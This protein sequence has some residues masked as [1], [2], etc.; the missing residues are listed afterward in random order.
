MPIRV[1][2]P[3]LFASLAL[4]G[5]LMSST[6]PPF[7]SS[8]SA[9]DTGA[10]AE[11]SLEAEGQAY[12][13]EK[14]FPILEANCFKC[15]GGED[16]LKGGFRVTS[17]EGLLRGGEL[18]SG[19]NPDAPDESLLLEMVSYKD[20]EHQMPP[21]EKL[22]PE[23]LAVLTEWFSRGA[24]YDPAL[25]IAGDPA[26]HKRSHISDE[27][28][29]YWA[30]QTVNETPVPKAPD[31]TWARNPVDAFISAKL[32]D[33]GL[34]PSP[35]ATRQVLV[36]RAYYDLIGLPPTPE[37][38]AKFVNDPRPEE[39]AWCDLIEDL[40]ERPQYGEKW[41]RHWLDLVRYA[42]TNGFERDN[43]KPEIWR[44]RDYI[45]NAFNSDKPYDRFVIEQLAGDELD[46]PTFDSLV[47]TGFH[48]LMQWDDEPADRKQHVYDVLADNLQVTAETFLGSTLGCARCHDHKADP[49][50][51]ED[52][53][54]FMAFFHGV[55]HYQTEGTLIAWATEAEKQK[56]ETERKQKLADL[57]QQKDKLETEILSWLRNHDFLKEGETEVLTFVANALDANPTDWF[58]AT[59][60]PSP[61]WMSVGFVNKSWLK[62]EGG[63][64]KE[65]TP[66]A[67]VR[68]PWKTA[69]IWM[70]A[71]FGLMELPETLALELHHDEDVE[72]YL[73]GVEVYRATGFVTQYQTIDLGPEA[74]AALQTGKNILAIHCH[75][76]KGGQYVDAA[77]RTGRPEA[78]SIK[79]LIK[80]EGGP[81]LANRINKDFGREIL[82]D[83]S[84]LE[85]EIETLR[86][87][88]PGIQINGVTEAGQNPE[89]MFIHIR[90]SAHAEGDPV[91]PAFPAVLSGTE[92]SKPAVIPAAYQGKN[93]SGRRRILAEWIASPENPLTARVMMNRLWQ[94]H[95]GRGIVPSTSDFGKLGE[96]PT[97]P[98]LLNWLAAEFIRQ[99]WS[100]K[101][102]HRLLM[103]SA[104]YQMSS[105]P[106][107]D[108]LAVDPTNNLFWRY[109]MRRL[110]AEEIRDSMLAL[111]GDLNLRQGGEPV[112]PPL[113]A[114]VL[115]TASRPDQAWGHSS[116]EDAARRSI[117]V[118]VKRSMR[119]PFLADFDQADTD[120]PCAVRFATTV[121]T[122]SL[123]MLNSEFVNTQA[124]TFARRIQ[125]EADPTPEAQVRYA[126]TLTLNREPRAEEV[127]EC[128]SLVNRLESELGMKPEDA[129]ERLAL[130]TMNLNEFVY[131]D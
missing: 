108:A 43:P 95:F 23:H 117:Y 47:A 75:Q 50:T 61:D 21:K 115:Q 19:Y 77:L 15:H 96:A 1:S 37:E 6:A 45:I 28:R 59:E 52:Y 58:Y 111:S 113:P 49:F 31:A 120:V 9:A 63:F 112:F 86:H 17:R 72:V 65:G 13:K 110:T 38:V 94:H 57:N 20:D 93:T 34:S 84:Q 51:Q 106:R 118:H 101:E 46:Q 91:A 126:L 81:R 41:A 22:A 71:Q 89:P 90:G 67:R 123:C 3:P 124:A 56:F 125:A 55:T 100:I 104:T 105:A 62:A 54:S 24:P 8:A 103:T 33:S 83:Y 99:G 16:K 44:Y 10:D 80:R 114:E 29:K 87:Q 66:G 102:M 116:P 68:T 11:V 30:Y 70:R 18:G 88:R 97:H 39:E 53:Y 76:T 85:T 79:A 131:L 128:V 36:R 12:Y 7:L 32:A 122:Q 5:W 107:Q 73:N 14:V 42:E 92:H 40:L 127:A 48:R 119:V 74:L 82:R 2:I 98:E 27:D 25:E 35:R 69:D 109:S 129:L 64:G 26:E 78:R 121:P 130:L 4:L 60:R